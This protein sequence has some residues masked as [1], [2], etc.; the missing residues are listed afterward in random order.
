MSSLQR[1]LG[2]TAEQLNNPEIMTNEAELQNLINNYPRLTESFNGLMDRLGG[3]QTLEQRTAEAERWIQ[4]NEAILGSVNYTASLMNL[5]KTKIL[6]D[7][8][9]K[10]FDFS[11]NFTI[12]EF[13]KRESAMD[14]KLNKAV[15]PYDVLWSEGDNVIFK[16][17]SDP[18]SLHHSFLEEDKQNVRTYDK[19]ES[20]F[21]VG[22]EGRLK[23]GLQSHGIGNFI[24][25]KHK[26]LIDHSETWSEY[27]NNLLN[28][29]VESFS[30]VLNGV[31]NK[32]SEKEKE[33]IQKEGWSNFLG[34]F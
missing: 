33:L 18:I 22:L 28:D 7:L 10:L 12:D 1:N 20:I 32:L 17:K 14:N 27:F 8:A 21:K 4:E 3:I 24:K 34:L 6:F 16:F 5:V 13:I 29:N 30:E 15:K 25:D 9:I 11:T 19:G 2:I 26:G 23:E 31:K